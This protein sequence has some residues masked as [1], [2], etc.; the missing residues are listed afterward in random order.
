MELLMRG[1]IILIDKFNYRKSFDSHSISMK[2]VQNLVWFFRFLTGSGLTGTGFGGLSM[3][4][5]RKESS[6]T[7]LYGGVFLIFYCPIGLKF[8]FGTHRK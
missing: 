1:F 8:K 6:R 2:K 4:S 3:V 7:R 5:I